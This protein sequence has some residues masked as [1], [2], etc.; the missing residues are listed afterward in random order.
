MENFNQRN[1]ENTTHEND[2]TE[3][4]PTNEER[5]INDVNKEFDEDV[6]LVNETDPDDE[7]PLEDDEDLE[8]ETPL[9][10]EEVAGKLPVEE[11]TDDFEDDDLFP[12]EDDDLEGE[13][14]NLE[15]K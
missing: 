7:V 2:F 3:R 6:P 13:A 5:W 10:D 8:E 1:T 15:F 11:P 4:E 9:N 14:D 12:D